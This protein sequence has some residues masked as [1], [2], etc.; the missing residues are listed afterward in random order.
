MITS[1]HDRTPAIH[2]ERMR[3]LGMRA[4][5]PRITILDLLS[6]YPHEHFTVDEI[7]T[8]LREEHPSL[9][10]TTV[11]NTLMAFRV[12]GLIHVLTIIE[13]EMLSGYGD[14]DHHHFYCRECGSIE[15]IDV[16]CPFMNSMLH[17]KHKVEE[18][19]GYFKGICKSCNQKE[20]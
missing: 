5:E 3:E 8:R 4:T 11:Y 7:F 9:S 13:S 10:K 2:A 15:D 17:G 19:H 18:I 6:T 12:K 1:N 20:K 16:S 14:S